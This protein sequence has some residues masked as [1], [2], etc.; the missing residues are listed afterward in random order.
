M[1]HCLRAIRSVR[2]LVLRKQITVNRYFLIGILQEMAISKF[3]LERSVDSLFDTEG[4]CVKGAGV[5]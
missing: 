1:I 4:G 2:Q 3:L 5:E